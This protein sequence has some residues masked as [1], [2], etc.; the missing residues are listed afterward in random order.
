MTQEKSMYPD[1]VID[2][3]AFVP[4]RDFAV[5]KQFYADLG[6]TLNF[7]DDQIA[8]YQVGAFR[9]LL[10]PFDVQQHAENFMMHLM[11]EDADA[12]WE[13]IERAGLREKYPGITANPPA[14]QAWG[15]RVLYLSDPV[16]VLWH[17]ADERDA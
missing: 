3:R 1:T 11:V 8:E 4:A 10:Q 6:F 14:M 5:S 9:F 13:W 17:I 16:G 7:G 2:L 15:L 12:W